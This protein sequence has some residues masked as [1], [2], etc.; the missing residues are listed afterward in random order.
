MVSPRLMMTDVDRQLAH[1][2]LGAVI[3]HWEA[4]GT[5]SP[6]GLR[7]AFLQREG[8]LVST[9][10]GWRLTVERKTLDILLTRIPWGFLT[11]KLPWMTSLLFVDWI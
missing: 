7:E 3:E 5:I 10:A 8:K 11:I 4:L 2:L 9:D 6:E 1:E